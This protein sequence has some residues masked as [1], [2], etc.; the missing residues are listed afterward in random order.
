[1]KLDLKRINSGEFKSI[2]N[3]I[4]GARAMLKEAEFLCEKGMTYVGYQDQ[5][6]FLLMGILP[7]WP[8]VAEAWVLHREGLCSVP[9]FVLRSFRKVIKM[10]FEQMNLH[11]LQIDFSVNDH[12]GFGL[13]KSAGFKEEGLMRRFTYDG[14]DRMRMA[15]VK[16]AGCR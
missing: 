1:M 2:S 11:R 3:E 14:Q 12:K 16:E 7:L 5:R 13:S 9:I 4:I 15:I 6:P 10:A 8:G